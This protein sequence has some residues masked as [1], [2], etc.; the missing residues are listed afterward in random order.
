MLPCVATNMLLTLDR[1]PL[2]AFAFVFST[3]VEARDDVGVSSRVQNYINSLDI[4]TF[5]FSHE[6]R[7]APTLTTSAAASSTL[8]RK[9]ALHVSGDK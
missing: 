2:T 7:L 6:G 5:S 8:D 4:S 9:R 1:L 3:P